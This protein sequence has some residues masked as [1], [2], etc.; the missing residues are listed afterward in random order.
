MS[1][2]LISAFPIFDKDPEDYP[3]LHVAEFFYDT[4]QGENFVGYPA[5]FLRVQHCS[6]NCIYC[7]STAVWQQGNPYGIKELVRMIISS[8]LADKFKDGQH[9]VLT[10]GSP[11]RQQFEIIHFLQE[12]ET[13]LGFLPYVEIENECVMKPSAR[14]IPLIKCWNNSPK[15][16][17]S[18]NSKVARYKPEVIAQTAAL[19]NSWFKFVITC[20][21]DWEEI[22][23]D[24]I[25]TGLINRK[26]I[27]LM[28]EGQTRE[29]LAKTA[30]IVVDMAVRYNV[31]YTS[32]EHVILWNKSTGV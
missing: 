5:A 6:L 12:L 11:L 31:R 25:E 20:E 7:D 28:P 29:E 15:L 21:E 13:Q 3:C 17:N 9:L 24:F 10:G 14:I 4:I 32:R 8:G 30:S 27:V 18:G 16:E 2:Q 1:K 23:K 19:E 26:Q 22:N